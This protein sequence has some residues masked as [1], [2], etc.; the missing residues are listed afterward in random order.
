[1]ATRNACGFN[2]WQWCNKLHGSH[3]LLSSYHCP[4]FVEVIDEC[5]MDMRDSPVQKQR[6]VE[7]LA[8]RPCD[9]TSSK[10][11]LQR[12]LTQAETRPT[13]RKGT[14]EIQGLFWMAK[15]LRHSVRGCTAR[16]Q[17]PAR[18]R[19]PPRT[20]QTEQLSRSGG[21]V[22]QGAAGWIAREH[23]EGERQ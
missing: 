22:Q 9:G 6:Q 17:L 19:G 4:P 12:H 16:P 5:N 7:P 15:G 18:L 21:P 14:P 23:A 10:P 3:S 20:T 1:V 13:G 11:C 8:Q 2:P